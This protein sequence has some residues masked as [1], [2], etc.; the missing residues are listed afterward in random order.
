MKAIENWQKKKIYA[1]ANSL[2]YVIRNADEEDPLHMIL[3]S[4][5]G[6]TSI[7]ELTYAEADKL[8]T[9]LSRLQE[10]VD[11]NINVSKA[12]QQKIWGL[13]YE[14]KACDLVPDF[15]PVGVRLAGIIKRQFDVPSSP[16]RLFTHLDYDDGNK[17]IEI[18][19]HYINNA[20]R[21][22]MN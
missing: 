6:K 4:M 19:K 5:T 18:M 21:K 3:Y 20:E 1:I 12:Q 14:L 16:Q 17:L 13:M 7:K 9:Y 15:T 22:R 8:I 10:D 2:H 11:K